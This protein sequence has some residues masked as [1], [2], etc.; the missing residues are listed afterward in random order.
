MVFR[1]CPYCRRWDRGGE[2]ACSVCRTALR[3]IQLGE[4]ASC[5]PSEHRWLAKELAKLLGEACTRLL[6]S[7]SS[8]QEGR[9]RRGRISRRE[10][11][12][13]LQEVRAPATAAIA[14]GR[15]E[16]PLLSK[17][18]GGSRAFGWRKE[19]KGP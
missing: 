15:A 6:L 17:R 2:A 18:R 4:S 5:G 1:P 16:L 3:F 14:G 11:G 10:T 13:L 8:H 9:E 19:G 7:P 12:L